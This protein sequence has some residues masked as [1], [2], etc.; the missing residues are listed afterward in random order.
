MTSTAAVVCVSSS[1]LSSESLSSAPEKPPHSSASSLSSSSSSSSSSPLR[2]EST[3]SS[4]S[5]SRCA[6]A[7]SS[8]SSRG[9]NWASKWRRK[10]AAASSSETSALAVSPS[11][12]LRLPRRAIA[13]SGSKIGRRAFVSVRMNIW[14]VVEREKAWAV[15]RQAWWK[16]FFSGRAGIDSVDRWLNPTKS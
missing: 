5:C 8:S 14:R 11:R 7:A 4:S 6:R 15:M 2:S 16:L 13:H 9:S 12:D 3:A 10:M 1:S